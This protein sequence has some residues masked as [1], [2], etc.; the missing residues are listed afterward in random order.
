[1]SNE[2]Q[3]RKRSGG[4]FLIGVFDRAFPFLRIDWVFLQLVRKA[5][6]SSNSRPF[7]AR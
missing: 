7:S 6:Q 2:N 1:M 4:V 3:A 5:R